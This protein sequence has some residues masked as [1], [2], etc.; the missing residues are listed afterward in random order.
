MNIEKRREVILKK[1]KELFPRSENPRIFAGPG[2]VNIIGGHTDYN[3]GLVLPTAVDREILMVAQNRNDNLLKMFSIDYNEGCEVS[4]NELQFNDKKK[5]ANYLLGVFYFLKEMG[6]K[7]N[8]VNLVFGGDIPQG[9]GMSSSAALEV[10]TAYT[11]RALQGLD[12]S[13][14]DLIKVSQKAENKFVGVMCGIMDQFASTMSKKDHLIFLDCADLSF[15]LIPIKFSDIKFVVCDTK[16]ERTLAGSEY[17]KRRQQCG[18]AVEILKKFIPGIRVLRDVSIDD[19]ER[20]KDKLPHPLNKRANHIIYEIDRV[21][22][23]ADALKQNNIDYIGRL[24]QESQK[25]MRDL[26]EISCNEL[27]VMV[28]LA[29]SV[30]GVYGTRIIGGGFG[31]CTISLVK[32][33][34]IEN[35]K[36]KILSEYPKKIGK[37][38]EIWV[39]ESSDGARE[40]K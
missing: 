7:I 22:K 23:V 6:F 3:S 16:K 2:R 39:C 15:E 29:D 21:R 13:G 12:L 36:S 30:K 19:F 4:L 9:G 31:G 26:F 17:N 20:Y 24:Q 27:D 10:G 18:E 32:A 40:I 1:F 11:V 35:F 28:E 14:V 5:W 34:S 25:S 8:G 38:S 37:I 33:E